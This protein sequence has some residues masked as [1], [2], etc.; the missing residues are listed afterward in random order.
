M[1]GFAWGFGGLKLPPSM[2]RWYLREETDNFAYIELSDAP[3]I[4]HLEELL[5]AGFEVCWATANGAGSFFACRKTM[6]AD[7]KKLRQY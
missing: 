6:A 3:S 7:F 1:A 5:V 2:P 4:Q